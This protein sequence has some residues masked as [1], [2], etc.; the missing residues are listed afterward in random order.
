MEQ[1]AAAPDIE[2]SKKNPIVMAAAKEI[3]KELIRQ[4]AKQIV[5]FVLK[6]FTKEGLRRNFRILVGKFLV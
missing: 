6:Q 1:F 5:K 3:A 2:N 4:M